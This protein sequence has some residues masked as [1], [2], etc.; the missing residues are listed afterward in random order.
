MH[1]HIITFHYITDQD[2]LNDT[3]RA[4]NTMEFGIYVAVR[5]GGSYDPSVNYTFASAISF[6]KQKLW[7]SRTELAIDGAN[8]LTANVSNPLC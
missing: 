8:A 2:P 7:I 5:Q 4:A 3:N 6:G 1:I